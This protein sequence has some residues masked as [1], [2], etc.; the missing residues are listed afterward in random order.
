MEALVADILTTLKGVDWFGD[1]FILRMFPTGLGVYLAMKLNDREERKRNEHRRRALLIALK[2]ELEQNADLL[3]HILNELDDA[4][5]TSTVDLSLIRATAWEQVNLF[6][7]GA[8]IKAIQALRFKLMHISR[9]LDAQIAVGG[10][11]RK[12]VLTKLADASKQALPEL[13][14]LEKKIQEKLAAAEA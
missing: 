3:R 4:R 7:D 5:I 2:T 8:F 6:S 1:F 14:A 10:E 12:K 11:D 9:Q 13:E